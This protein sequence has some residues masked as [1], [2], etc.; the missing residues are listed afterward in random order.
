M[1]HYKNRKQLTLMKRLSIL[2]VVLLLAACGKKTTDKKTELAELKKQRTELD[3]KI[4]KLET[5]VGTKDSG[6]VKEVTAVEITSGVF[7][8][9][10]EIQGRVD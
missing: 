8:N 9:Y 4:S 2:A 10:V 5:E 3:V 7:T 1:A 6:S